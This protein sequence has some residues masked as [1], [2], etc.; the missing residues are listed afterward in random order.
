MA[1][2]YVLVPAWLVAWEQTEKNRKNCALVLSK[3]YDLCKQKNSDKLNLS[4]KELMEKLQMTV[5]L[6]VLQR[7]LQQLD[8]E[9][10]IVREG[11][12]DAQ[13]ITLNR[14]KYQSLCAV[15]EQ[16]I[17]HKYFQVY[18]FAINYQFLHHARSYVMYMLAKMYQQSIEIGLPANMSI[19]FVHHMLFD[20]F[21]I[22]Q[23]RTMMQHLIDDGILNRVL[24]KS[25]D[26]A[27]SWITCRRFEVRT[28][29]V[30]EL[31]DYFAKQANELVEAKQTM[32]S[33]ATISTQSTRSYAK[34]Q[35]I[36]SQQSATVSWDGAKSERVNRAE[37][38]AWYRER[39][40]AGNPVKTY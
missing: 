34:K 31:R 25:C 29:K 21:T 39:E 40:L 37:V 4:T 8:A 27:K 28:E 10:M 15:F 3:V 23:E 26:E 14:E 32:Y 9:K 19:S 35:Q 33:Y 30:D 2:Y 36:T 12:K 7:S 16:Y 38:D 5:P 6:R 17:A 11:T 22:E 1:D 13:T 20:V 24:E 18:Y